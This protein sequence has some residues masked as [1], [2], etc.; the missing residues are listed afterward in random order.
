MAALSLLALGFAAGAKAAPQIKPPVASPVLNVAV[1][2]VAPIIPI[3]T[4]VAGVLPLSAGASTQLG[5]A[6]LTASL[7]GGVAINNPLTRVT[8]PSV[9]P[10]AAPTFAVPSGAVPSPAVA[11]GLPPL[12]VPSGVPPVSIP[13]GV[14]PLS[15]PNGLPPLSVPNGLPPLPVPNG[16]PPLSIPNPVQAL[17]VPVGAPPLPVPNAPPLAGATIPGAANILN[18]LALPGGV[19]PAVSDGIPSTPNPPVGSLGSLPLPGSVAVPPTPDTDPVYQAV[20]KVGASVVNLILAAF[21]KVP[22]VVSSIL[23]SVGSPVPSIPNVGSVVPNVGN[24]VPSLP[25]VGGVAPNV[26]SLPAVGSV[27]NGLPIG[28]RQ[29]LPAVSS[30]KPSSSPTPSPVA[31]IPGGTLSS[32]TGGLLGGS[33]SPLGVVTS[34][35]PLGAVTDPL[36]DAA[37]SVGGLTGAV[38][39]GSAPLGIV[40]GVTGPA[41]GLTGAASGIAG[42]LAGTSSPLGAVASVASGSTSGLTGGSSPLGAVTG[43]NGPLGVVSG[44]TAPVSGAVSD[45]LGT[46]SQTASGIPIVG[47]VANNAVGGVTNTVG[48]VAP[49]LN[50]YYALN[51]IQGTDPVGG[52]GVGIIATLLGLLKKDPMSLFA[53]SLPV[54]TLA[55]RDI[56]HLAERTAEFEV[57]EL[58]RRQLGVPVP[59]TG[60]TALPSLSQGIPGVGIGS[61]VGSGIPGVSP[62]VAALVG[63]IGKN[64]A[65]PGGNGLGSVTGNILTVLNGIIPNFVFQL[66]VVQ[67]SVPTFAVL[68]LL[69]AINPGKFKDLG[70]LMTLPALQQASAGIPASDLAFIKTLPASPDPSNLI[71]TVTSYTDNVLTL[72]GNVANLK[73]SAVALSMKSLGLSVPGL[74]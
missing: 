25:N 19:L 1:A 8:L 3:G 58:Q 18:S 33:S 37:N 40:S 61:L 74:S 23:P 72:P 39:S 6:I 15:V 53:P 11:G 28:K 27:A 22:G 66:P 36:A 57:P 52:L 2:P 31:A 63:S 34:G 21:T 45:P 24:V 59:S 10:P 12:A 4:P 16:L 56:P 14:P 64:I 38:T 17:P 49:N 51:G 68:Q 41:S 9:T 50:P 55:Q 71:T 62:D 67:D 26:G 42:G 29:L 5:N 73:A 60:S 46:V 65:I 20:C 30:A 54:S 32:L 44:A 35:T 13:G 43:S 47:G 69:A 48:K 70:T 7:G